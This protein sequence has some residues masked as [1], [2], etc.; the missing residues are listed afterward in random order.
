M[1]DKKVVKLQELAAEEVPV[2]FKAENYFDFGANPFEHQQLFDQTK[3]VIEALASIGD[4]AKDWLKR[5][6]DARLGQADA[7]RQVYRDSVPSGIGQGRFEIIVESGAVFDP[8]VVVGSSGERGRVYVAAGAS[9]IGVNLWVGD[10]DI[11]IGPETVVEPGAGI[12]GPT[13][14]GRGNELRQGTYLRGSIV[15]GNKGVFRG[16]IKNAVMMDGANFPHPGYVGDSLCGYQTHFG[17]QA[18]TA[19]LGLFY[20]LGRKTNVTV[21]LDGTVYDLGRP[22]VGVIL[23]D[24]TQVGC[25]TVT[26]PG[27]FLGPNTVVYPLTVLPKGVNPGELLIKYKP[28]VEK[29]P[30]DRTFKSVR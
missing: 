26:A 21:E 2:A 3:D 13:I 16:E 25:G 18:G 6:I 8:A 27:G 10:G 20:A 23:G 11:Y 7:S 4:Y 15:I 12:K 9:V 14:I 22:K 1:P 30:F 5:T 28:T 19:N 17:N 29:A 24:F